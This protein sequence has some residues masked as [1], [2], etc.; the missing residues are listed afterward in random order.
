M[1]VVNYGG[2]GVVSKYVVRVCPGC[3][4][5]PSLCSCSSASLDTSAVDYLSDLMG[6]IPDPLDIANGSTKQDRDVTGVAGNLTVLNADGDAVDAGFTADVFGISPNSVVQRS[7]D[8]GINLTGNTF[9]GLFSV[10][11]DSPGASSGSVN[12]DF[13]HTFLD[14]FFM[15]SGIKRESGILAFVGAD[16]VANRALQRGELGL[17]TIATR[18]IGATGTFTSLDGKSI[19]VVDGVITQII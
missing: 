11:S 3:G 4:C 7:S 1:S 16:A 5:V 2:P 8:G 6:H 17:G 14:A 15:V 9:A 10:S 19:T 18:N 13:A 12:N